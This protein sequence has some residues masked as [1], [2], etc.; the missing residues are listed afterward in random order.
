MRYRA[1]ILDHD[2]TAIDSTARVH[3][4]SHVRS[5][6]LL[7]PGQPTVDLETWFLKNFH[8]GIM[9]FLRDELGLDDRELAL[10][11]D[12]WCEG[13]ASCQPTFYEGFLETLGEFR[14]RGGR[15]AIASHAHPEAILRH[16][17]EAG[18]DL[19]PE[20]VFGWDADPDRRKPHPFPVREVLRQ[21]ALEP[22]E[23]LVLD[24]LRPGVEMAL[25][26]GVA[27]AAAGWGHQIAPIRAYMEAHCI[28][29]FE[30]VAAFRDFLFQ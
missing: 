18:L 5:M 16:Y 2:D 29:Y 23:V 1:L 12:I 14:A 19:E 22:G 11:A 28:A 8:P 21:L 27:V 4:P 25:A 3:Y 24:D 15:L 10:E 17:R 7:R 30:A 20:L 13:M 26:A 6:A 9:A